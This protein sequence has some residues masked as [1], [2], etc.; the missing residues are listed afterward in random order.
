MDA[1]ATWTHL[2]ASEAINAHS[3][4]WIGVSP[5]NTDSLTIATTSGVFYS[6]DGGTS[7]N[8][9][10]ISGKT[11]GFVANG[12]NYNIQHAAVNNDG[13]YKSTDAGK[14]W[15][16]KS[17]SS[18]SGRITLAI[19]KSNPDVVYA[20]EN[21]NGGRSNFHKT[22]DGGESWH[23][24]T[25]SNPV[26]IYS[27]DYSR[28]NGSG[29]QGWYDQSLIVHPA[30]PD[31]IFAGG[32]DIYRGISTNTSSIELELD[33]VDNRWGP[34]TNH[35][36]RSI[37]QNV[38]PDQ[39]SAAYVDHGNGSYTFIFGGDGGIYVTS[40]NSKSYQ[41]KVAGL[42]NTLFYDAIKHPNQD[43]YFGGLQDNGT[44]ISGLDPNS[45]SFWTE[46][47]S[48]DGFDV[49]WDYFNGDRLIGGWYNQ[50]LMLSTNGGT[51]FSYVN[52][53]GA[54]KG[55]FRNV[56]ASSQKARDLLALPSNGRI[57][58]SYD[59]TSNWTGAVPEGRGNNGLSSRGVVR[60]SESNP[61]IIWAGDWFANSDGA[62][63]ST[64]MGASFKNAYSGPFT[65]SMGAYVTGIGTHPTED[66]TAFYTFS[67]SGKPHIL[68]TKDLGQTFEDI[69]GTGSNFPDVATYCVKVMPHNTNEIWAGTEIGLF[70][71]T[72]NGATWSYANNGIPA[73]VIRNIRIVKD[74]IIVATFG[75]GIY[76]ADITPYNP[77]E[78]EIR[79]AYL[80]EENGYFNQIDIELSTRSSN[81]STVVHTTIDGVTSKHNLGQLELGSKKLSYPYTTNQLIKIDVEVFK[82][83][84]KYL[85]GEKQITPT[86]KE[87][88]TQAHYATNF[89]TDVSADFTL[90]GFITHSVSGFSSNGLTTPHPYADKTVYTA[91][92]KTPIVV[93]ENAND[94]VITFKEVAIVEPGDSQGFWDYSVVEYSKDG[95]EWKE[96]VDIYDARAHTDWLAAYNNKTNG[97][98]S[99][100]KP[101][102]ISLHSKVS[103]GDVIF[104]RF[105]MLADASVNSWG[106]HIDDLSV[107][108][109]TPKDETH[110]NL[111]YRFAQNPTF[112]K[113]GLLFVDTDRKLSTISGS[114]TSNK[115][116]KSA[117]FAKSSIV[118]G[119]ESYL[120]HDL[121]ISS[122]DTTIFYFETVAISDGGTPNTTSKKDTLEVISYISNQS[123]SKT[124]AGKDLQLTL[125]QTDDA[126]FFIAN[127][128]RKVFQE[129]NVIRSIQLG[130]GNAFSSDMELS[131][132]N[133]NK[134]YIYAYV[135]DK[136]GNIKE[137]SP[138]ITD[139]GVSVRSKIS[140]EY[141]FVEKQEINQNAQHIPRTTELF[142][143]Y[144][145]PF[146]PITT[147]RF[148]LK[149]SSFVQ[150]EIYNLLGQKVKTLVRGSL[151]AKS[152]EMR[153]AGK[154]D[155]GQQVASGI[156][157]YKL[158]TPNGV[159]TKK[160]VLLK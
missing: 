47:I 136:D 28:A 5:T 50:N 55:P 91:Q 11:T 15:T 160:M 97:S 155:Y 146:N 93:A 128:Y 144:P 33:A 72:D 60:I 120:N 32:I 139:K 138:I 49:V 58:V 147:I 35:K 22:V 149:S 69:T 109:D 63:L 56:I 68:R 75:H 59:F 90:D 104:I 135:K 76:V 158:I 142:Q 113:N 23:A 66:S 134:E 127:T 34:A 129:S 82:P 143:N 111:S 71:S 6:T 77:E 48:G 78:Q 4:T 133:N 65:S 112:P 18:I 88:K 118:S 141:F 105:R 102:S 61:N 3:V 30:N 31:T 124:L 92:L 150:L 45:E 1:G 154:N 9:T 156:Y 21:S 116:N 16:K 8:A 41:R 110:A 159:F 20:V 64:D 43:Q 42:H 51:S 137:L 106:W 98:E 100:F 95:K 39:H 107:Q 140:G 27:Y 19:S 130:S 54:G 40:D 148:D 125:P 37:A 26:N 29:G 25:Q 83:S 80:A 17:G 81:D 7:F 87:V 153:W 94:A 38:H 115:V 119:T 96:L 85:I 36:G 74:E 73:V 145:N 126:V 89:D 86:V 12:N 84:G 121:T 52:F 131:L 24:L 152:Y 123:S 2:T 122:N 62:L 53:E 114:Y 117:T 132:T 57:Y 13:V 101:R 44:M 46:P 103:A 99:L 157:F 10:N 108:K 70:I 14:T 151:Q 67:V 79:S